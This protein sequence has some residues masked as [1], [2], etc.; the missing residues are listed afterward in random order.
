MFILKNVKFSCTYTKG[1]V[2]IPS[3][4]SNYR[5]FVQN[6]EALSNSTETYIVKYNSSVHLT[7]KNIEINLALN[8]DFTTELCSNIMYDIFLTHIR[9]DKLLNKNVYKISKITLADEMLEEDT[10][11]DEEKVL[12]DY[13]I[14]EMFDSVYMDVKTKIEH[15]KKILDELLVTIAELPKTIDQIDF[16]VK[17]GN[18]FD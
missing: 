4:K 12:D 13:E 18:Q 7:P 15:K 10:I 16:L 14:C 6:E 1:I 8:K 17:T 11:S 2:F 5:D 9:I 3:H